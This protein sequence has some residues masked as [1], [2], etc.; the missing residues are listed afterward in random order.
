MT[1]VTEAVLEKLKTYNG[2]YD[3]R[4]LE[5]LKV[6]WPPKRGWR[7]NMIG[8]TVPDDLLEVL[9]GI[10]HRIRKESEEKQDNE[11]K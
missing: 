4:T 3:R 11:D 10:Q 8:K 2:G 7:K 5:A 6:G 9:F 1:I